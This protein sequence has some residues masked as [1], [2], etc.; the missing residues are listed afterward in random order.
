MLDARARLLLLRSYLLEHTDER[1]GVSARQIIAHLEL[2]GY[3]ADRRAIYADIALLRESG[4]DIR[5]RRTRANEYYVATRTFE[6][7]ELRLLM[8]MIRASRVLSRERSEAMIDKLATLL[9]R[10]DASF[11]RRQ[12]GAIGPHK[13]ENERAFHNAQQILPALEA[14]QKLSFLYCQFTAK[15]ALQPRR[16]GERYIVSPC[17][18]IYAE[19]H[20]YLIA[21]HPSHEGLAHY[22]LDKMEEVRALEEP[23]APADLSFDAA[24]YAKTV[25][26]MAPAQQRWVHLRFDRALLGAML[27]RFGA[28]VPVELLDE[29]TYALFA[30]VRV[31]PPFFG[32]V[33]QFGGRV[34]IL[35]PDDVREEMLLMLEASRLAQRRR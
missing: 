23:A 16:G 27:D 5:V 6:R 17:L 3:S 4:L 12:G 29:E 25:F 28:D 2:S 33:F 21:D 18:L 26:S 34:S 32:W 24:A 7:A 19:D 30:P 1:H 15:K 14:G 10:H 13:A 35:A 8:D 20:Y 11:L 22:R 9:S 31:S